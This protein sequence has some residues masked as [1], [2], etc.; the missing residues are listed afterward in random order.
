MRTMPTI[1]LVLVRSSCC[2][3]AQDAKRR[4]NLSA[5]LAATTT[6]RRYSQL[7]AWTRYI[8]AGRAADTAPARTQREKHGAPRVEGRGTG[9]EGSEER[10][11]S[12]DRRTIRP[13]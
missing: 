5:E 3:E 12:S 7:S 9:E 11:K 13:Y 6:H 4:R 2:L 10:S 1:A 8:Q